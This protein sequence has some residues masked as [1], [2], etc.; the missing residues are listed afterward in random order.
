M[1]KSHVRGHEIYWDQE[2]NIWRYCDTGEDIEIERLCKKC[3]KFPTNDGYD[4]CLGHI[5]GATHA[6]CG[7]GIEK[8]Y[9]IFNKDELLAEVQ[10]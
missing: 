6:C 8:P 3:G 9:I 5:E 1:I 7:H 4:A 2:N 10:K